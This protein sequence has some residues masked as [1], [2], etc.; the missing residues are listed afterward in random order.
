MS[1]TDIL[2]ALVE[3][4]L[5]KSCIESLDD[6]VEHSGVAH[7]ENPPGR[8]SG[9]YPWGSGNRVHQ[10]DWDI[11][12]RY[13]KLQA[14]GMSPK[15]IAA[16]MGYYKYD[17]A[18]NII[19]DANGNPEGNTT[20]LRAAKQIA[21]NNV[22]K[23]E[24]QEILWYSTH[25]NPDTGQLYSTS[26]IARIL[27][28]NE[29]TVRSK[30]KTGENG[31]IDKTTNVANKLKEACAEKGY[32]DVGKGTELNLGISPDGLK[33]SLEML[34]SEGYT[35]KEI[36][37][38]QVG[39]TNG[40]M[41]RFKVLCPPGSDPDNL[42]RH[43]ED[44]KT[45]DDPTGIDE[46]LRKRGLAKPPKVDI[47]RV[48]IKYAEEGGTDRDGEIQ[49]RA[50]RDK[51]G[52]LVP[53]CPDLSLG[54]AKYAQVRIAVDGGPECIT[55]NNPTGA[56]Y[57]KGM[58][59]YS[60][61]LPKGVDILV[62]SNKSIDD[63]PKK[64]LKDMDE[65]AINPFGSTVIQTCV[66]DKNGHYILDKNGNQIPSA[67]NIVGSIQTYEKDSNGHYI[68]DK[69]G[70]LIP[71]NLVAG[72]TDAHMEGTWGG[73]SKNLPS[74]FLAKQPL[75]LVRKQLKLQSQKQEADLDEIRS[76][77]NPIV[78]KHMLLDYADQ[79]DKAAEDLK[80][81][82]F[83]GQKT[84]VIL[85][86][87]SL[88]DNECY[89][90][91]FDNGQTVAL[92]RFPHTGPPEIPIL[93]VN[94]GNAE[95][96]SFMKNAQDAIGINQHV[97][98]KLSGADFDGDTVIAIPVTKKMSNGEFTVVNNIKSAPAF[99]HLD[100]FDPTAAYSTK[101]PRFK[102]MVDSDGEP[103]YKYFKTDRE[104]G[105]EMGVI[106]NL[107]TDM[108]AKGCSDPEELS[109]AVRYS[110]VVIDAKKHKLNYQQAYK[111]YG[112]QELKDKYQKKVSKNGKVSYGASSLLSK[113]KS[114]MQVP[115]RSL[116][117]KIDP[118]TGKKL[119]L[120]PQNKSKTTWKP[121]PVDAPAGYTWTDK[122][123][124]THK[125]KHLKD[126]NGKDIV[127]T[128]DGKVVKD[129]DGNYIYDRG[130][131]KEQWEFQGYKPRMQKIHK[132][133]Y[134]DDANAL[135]SENPNEIEKSYAAYANH[136]KALANQAR[137]ESLDP[138][139]R[140][141]MNPEAKKL[142][143][144]EVAELEEASIKAKKN[145]PRERQA[146]LLATSKINAALADHPEYSSEER[147]KIRG[148]CLKDARIAT[149]AQKDRIIF[150]PSQWK[151]INAGAVSSSKLEDLLANADKDNYISLALPKSSRI[152]DAQR[153]TIKSLASAG[154]SQED[155]AQFVGISTSSISDV[156]SA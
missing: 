129:A 8:G 37:L 124:K 1:N 138:S 74:Q 64:A 18:G 100:G 10:R 142:Y 98:A 12:T 62:N 130:S 35:V 92:V 53:A 116:R 38:K 93:K 50:V 140:L 115:A 39:A 13:Q 68:T 94:N 31:N 41:T 30:K 102:D 47:S 26:E 113:S 121:V 120:A 133:Q 111:D 110:M 3:D 40:Q 86:V 27:G 153:A 4:V 152:T 51:N 16:A 77:N 95:A 112:I 11:Y 61:K 127:A 24:Y 123:G 60:D 84:H 22:K 143:S 55:K 59:V 135:L 17:K 45:V 144:K 136:C 32:I 23:D 131:G 63:G 44:I 141:K 20:K 106:S 85:P 109:R 83:S 128:Y 43:P 104:K 89:A 145:A 56:K 134:Y 72:Q 80:A 15:E 9:R 66:R 54:N 137:K 125:S 105:R 65:N 78:K 91:N 132:M 139:L 36:D 103:T 126:K 21:T 146:Q 2:Q 14:S 117:Y 119:Y 42:W 67:I 7:D 5:T 97:A 46:S 71:D 149:G 156:L 34:K 154:W 88:K 75:N 150:T 70:S 69:S 81:A 19:L 99:P 29:S 96:N 118:E 57:I 79:M 76:L 147:R 114:E 49:I 58:A 25:T 107:I 148:E 108:Y 82:P 6:F 33:T 155:I 90:P 101:N 151:A 87:P 28:V 52:N 73:W 48:Q 122:D